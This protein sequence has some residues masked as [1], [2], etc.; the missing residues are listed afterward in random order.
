MRFPNRL[1]ALI[2]GAQGGLV[3]LV[4]GC[5]TTVIGL[6]SRG[7]AVDPISEFKYWIFWS[8]PLLI[9]GMLTSYQ[10]FANDNSTTT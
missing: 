5:F 10:R 4:V 3:F 2:Y 9:F 1:T 7:F 8:I 6:S